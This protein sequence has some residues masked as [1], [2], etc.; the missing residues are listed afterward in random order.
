MPNLITEKVN[1]AGSLH[2]TATDYAK[3]LGALFRGDLITDET[4]TM[5][6]SPQQNVDPKYSQCRHVN[7]DPGFKTFSRGLGI[8]LEHTDQDYI[9]H[10]GDNGNFKSHFCVSLTIG[11][12]LVYLAGSHSGLAFRDQLVSAVLPGRHPA[13]KWVKYIQI[14]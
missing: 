14:E 8:G 9:R 12:G 1:A 6:L 3:F 13:H 7:S 5:I 10:W 4:R 2:T 11:K